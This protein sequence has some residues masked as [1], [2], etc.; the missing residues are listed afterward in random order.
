MIK[1]TFFFGS[2]AMA[3][4]SLAGAG[5]V[6][7]DNAVAASPVPDADAVDMLA[8][9]IRA[10]L[11]ALPADVSQADAETAILFVIDQAKQASDV[12]LAALLQVQSDRNWSPNIAAAIDAIL[13][14]RGA[15]GGIRREP[16]L[17][18]TGGLAG[19]GS[20]LGSGPSIGGG[21]GGTDYSVP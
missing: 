11:K 13:L 7:D 21:G 17:G 2:I 9:S 5:V 12:T 4:A 16:S 19:A 8:A 10:S 3:S 6:L 18:A 14:R 20:G 1:K 15:T